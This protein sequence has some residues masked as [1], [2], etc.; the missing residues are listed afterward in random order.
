[1]DWLVALFT[2]P[3]SIAHILF[4][5]SIVIA[6]GMGLGRIKISYNI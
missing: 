4:V 6:L 2:N 1:M 3:G 5:Y